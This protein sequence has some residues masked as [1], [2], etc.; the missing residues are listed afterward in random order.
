MKAIVVGATGAVGRDLVQ[1]LCSDPRYTEVRTFARREL[2]IEHKKLKAYVVDFERTEGWQDLVQGDVI[3]S[4]LGT[5]K[6]Q[7]GSKA[8]QYHVD[9]DYQMMFAEFAKKHGVRH[10][11]LVSS[12]G[13]DARSKFFYL[14]LKGRIEDEMEALGF[15]GLTI[16][17]PPSLIRKHAKRPLETVSVKAIQALNA[18][19][20]FKGMA[21]IS[22]ELVARCMADAGAEDFKGVRRITGQAIRTFGK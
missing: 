18:I 14:N 1:V 15:A 8:A 9:H 11:V 22:T 6:K 16:L 13:A 21:P 10:M 3:F 19:G 17:Q 20:L 4:A 2:G 7:A 12:V 5:S